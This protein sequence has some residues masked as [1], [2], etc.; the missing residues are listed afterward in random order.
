MCTVSSKWAVQD[1]CDPDH[2]AGFTGTPSAPETSPTHWPTARGKSGVAT[3][4]P[5]C[6]VAG[7]SANPDGHRSFTAFPARL[8]EFVTRLHPHPV[9]GGAPAEVCQRHG[10]F[11]Q[12]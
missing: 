8:C 7:S 9:L 10:G 12:A 3:L 11:Q 5:Y 1:L 2:F 6:S 4:T